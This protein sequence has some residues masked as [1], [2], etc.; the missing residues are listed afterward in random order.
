M[1]P[2]RAYAD[3]LPQ[4]SAGIRPQ[5]SPADARPAL[6]VAVAASDVERF[7]ATPFT[8]LAARNTTEA[9][10]LLER[11][12]PRVV[13]IDWD[14]AD[15]DGVAICTAARQVAATAILVLTEFPE[16]APVALKAGCHAVLLKPFVPNLLAARIGRLCREVPLAPSFRATV[17]AQQP[18]TNRT[19]PDVVCP[20]CGHQGSVGFEFSSHRR[21][22]YACLACEA[23]WLGVRRE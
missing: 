21:T 11:W 22:W 19:W 1:L 20:T 15:F 5:P 8:R 16:R 13:A 2:T 17:A 18:G 4:F 12:R 23:V 3:P 10:R 6:V 9:V 14:S 7:P